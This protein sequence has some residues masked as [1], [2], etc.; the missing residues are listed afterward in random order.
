M[1]YHFTST[2]R[3]LTA[4]TLA[5]V[6]AGAVATGQ[7][8]LVELNPSSS[9]LA[10]TDAD[11]ASGGRING[12][13]RASA[14]T[15]YAASE[16]AGLYK[17]TDTGRTWSR[18]NR[19]LPTATWDVETSP[20]D[21]NRVIA[22]S[23]YDGKV[24][25]LAGIN[26]S[27]DGGQTWTHPP[28]VTPAAAFC[29]EAARR[30]EPSAFGIAFDP[31]NAAN[32]YVGTNCGLA[33]SNDSG[34]TWR[35]VDPTPGDPPDDIWDV[36]VHHNGTI[37]LCG[38]DGH[39][40][41]TNGGT[42]WT[43]ATASALPSGR[44]ALAASPAEAHVLFAVSGIRIFE[45]D[46]GGGSWT[47]QFT[48]RNPQGRVPF[49]ATNP[50]TANAFDLWFGDVELFRATCT[51]PT[52]AQPG[53]SPRCPDANA[54]AGPFT[55]AAGAHD[56]VGDMLFSS[57]AANACPVL[58]SSDGGVF[59]NSRT[60]SPA[61]HTP[62]W[63]QPNVTP[64]GLWLFGMGGARRQT[65]AHPDLYFGAQ[66]NGAFASV[67]GGQTWTNVDCCDSFDDVAS[68]DRVL[69][70]TC[71]FSSGPANVI[72]VA[73]PGMTGSAA[74]AKMPPGSM[75]GWTAADTLDR[76]GRHA[77]VAVTSSGVFITKDVTAS[78]LVWSQ[79]GA[80]SSPTGACAVQVAG[81]EVSPTFVVQAGSCNGR[82]ADALFQ[83]SGTSTGTWKRIQPAAG[84]TGFVLF[85]VDRS[86]AR[87]LASAQMRPAGPAMMFST[88][89]GA[90][91]TA[92]TALDGLMTGGGKYR[93]RT[94]RGPT[95]FTAFGAYVQPTL[96]AF[97]P[98]DRNTIIAGAADAGLFLSRNGGSTWTVVTD[99]SGT[100]TAP[101]LPRPS[102]AHFTRQ[103][104][105]AR[106]YVGTQGRG[107]W[108]VQ[109]TLATPSNITT[110]APGRTP[111]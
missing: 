34:A 69:Y 104:N 102:F 56:D 43:T 20:T 80:S 50:R 106:V 98:G 30:E 12:L 59:V 79:L 63:K 22:T 88:D 10:T 15:F 85:A 27:T 2:A 26:V 100:A 1:T 38:D 14:T 3:M 66:D 67:D 4:V 5:L 33:I 45:S 95:D 61:C 93:A 37:D 28:T 72:F 105:V 57:N 81:D 7:L 76:Y 58:F 89:G 46:N 108:R 48:N 44:C 75:A 31:A 13:A 41:S 19:H 84:A 47:K 111:R 64:H 18:L 21:P 110:P 107:I 103:G 92:N 91:W 101:I 16:W 53:G 94:R 24:A 25:S 71:C 82:S 60:A 40:R 8:Q 83:F 77:Y 39:R 62:A 32:V 9:S 73:Q 109:F 90:T 68:A 35:F 55:R 70:T 6:A 96:V 49:V 54:W 17:S 87:H 11:G 23:F 29:S 51:T 36:I 99:S 78:P 74:I 52:P 42:T 97:D 65:S 86:D